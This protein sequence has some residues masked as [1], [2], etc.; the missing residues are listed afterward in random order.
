MASSGGFLLCHHHHTTSVGSL[1][2]S[3]RPGVG[4]RRK[5]DSLVSRNSP[6]WSVV[7]LDARWTIFPSAQ[8]RS[9]PVL[10][11]RDQYFF[12]FYNI[13]EAA[14]I[15][16]GKALN[17]VGALVHCVFYEHCEGERWSRLGLLW[18]AVVSHCPA[19]R[20][21]RV[22]LY[23]PRIANRHKPRAATLASLP[24]MKCCGH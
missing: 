18:S 15:T 24:I 3:T 16:R 8:R 14:G 17:G 19:D 21:G 23:P 5:T 1:S 12:F 11:V 4:W 22:T 2:R 13:T 7:A 20:L 9:F 10:R 6:V